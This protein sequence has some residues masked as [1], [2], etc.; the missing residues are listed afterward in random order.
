LTRDL[1]LT[2]DPDLLPISVLDDYQGDDAME[3]DEYISG[4][5]T[6]DEEENIDP[7]IRK[8]RKDEEGKDGVEVGKAREWLCSACGTEYDKASIEQQLVD[9]VSRRLI[10][11]QLQDVKC[12]RCKLVKA[13]NLREHW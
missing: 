3:Q 7:R 5:D 2:R 1:D 9:I 11:W 10:S 12:N 13:E 8:G 6:E 4:S